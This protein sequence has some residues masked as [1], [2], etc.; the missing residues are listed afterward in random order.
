MENSR[1]GKPWIGTSQKKR[2]RRNDHEIFCLQQGE[3]WRSRCFF[4][5]CCHGESDYLRSIDKACYVLVHERN[6][7]S[8]FTTTHIKTCSETEK[9]QISATLVLRDRCERL[10]W[11]WKEWRTALYVLTLLSNHQSPLASICPWLP[12]KDCPHSF[13]FRSA[14]KSCPDEVAR[15]CWVICL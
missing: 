11:W 7:V 9:F 12:S 5:T 10:D 2:R 8:K 6:P 3:V 1:C 15:P 4:S 14:A 13:R